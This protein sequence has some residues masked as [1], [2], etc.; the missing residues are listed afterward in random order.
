VFVNY[1]GRRKAK[2]VGTSRQLAEQVRRQF[3]A[4]LALGD[5]GF[6][7]A[8][9]QE[10]P[11]F[12][13]YAA[14]WLKRYAEL[15][16]KP[17]TARSY[18]QLLRVHVTPRFGK[19]KLAEIKRDDVKEFLAELRRATRVVNGT[20]VPKF[21]RNTLRLILTALRTV[22]YAAVEDHLI[23]SNP[24]AKML[25]KKFVKSDKPTHQ[26]SAMMR[27]E[28][29]GFLAAVNEVCPEWYPFFLTALRA[30]LFRKG[31]LIALKWDDL[32]FGA[33]E[34]DPNRYILVQ[35][36]YVYGKFTS[37]KNKKPRRV[38]MS[39]HLR[40]VLVELRDERLLAAMMAGKMSIADDL[41]FPSQAGTVLKPDNIAPR[42]MEPALEKAGLRPFRF[43][44][45][46][47]PSVVC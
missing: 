47:Q 46:R 3:E 27:E 31:E 25:K 20:P 2:C 36:N 16:C 35:Q 13:D 39:R 6:L 29:E 33:D 30:G 43:H 23:E 28:A 10:I 12:E 18:E 34:R 45:L 7:E 40:S 24:A 5:L 44:D 21:S 1:R 19:Q 11:R 32:Q 9:G 38:D 41:V 14:R 26:A 17:S 8:P 37:P 15:E 42:Y 4:K 22:R